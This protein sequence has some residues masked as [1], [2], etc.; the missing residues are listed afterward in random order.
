MKAKKQV[1]G[2]AKSPPTKTH[3]GLSNGSVQS[4]R[5]FNLRQ[6]NKE[7][8]IKGNQV[9]LKKDIRA[10]AIKNINRIQKSPKE[11]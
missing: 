5:D 7:R 10:A 6:M 4:A 1:G 2:D 3:V 8:D 11:L 9:Q